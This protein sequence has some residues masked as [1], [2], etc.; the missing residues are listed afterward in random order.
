MYDLLGKAYSYETPLKNLDR[1]VYFFQNALRM[2][3]GNAV[4]NFH[5]G[6]AYYKQ[7]KFDPALDYLSIAMQLTNE[8]PDIYKI[9][10]A[11]YQGKGQLEEAIKYYDLYL[12]RIPNAVD[13]PSISQQVKDL[14]AQLN[15]PQG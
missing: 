6:T 10:A 2:D 1:S 7:Q 3:P 12:K 5:L 8:I 11:S 14:R 13:A 4:I 9:V 15:P